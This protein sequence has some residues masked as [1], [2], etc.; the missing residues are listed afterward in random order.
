MNTSAKMSS[1]EKFKKLVFHEFEDELSVLKESYTD[2][3]L[4]HEKVACMRCTS[5]SRNFQ[6]F[7]NHW[8]VCSNNNNSGKK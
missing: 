8:M 2:L 3:M 1:T 6:E 4:P 7:Q 5:M